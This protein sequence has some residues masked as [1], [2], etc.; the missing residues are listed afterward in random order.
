MRQFALLARSDDGAYIAQHLFE[1]ESDR[2]AVAVGALKVMKLAY[3]MVQP[4]CD[5][6][7]DLVNDLNVVIAEMGSKQERHA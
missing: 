3:P 1:A 2:D 4:W 7:I 6:H 5:G